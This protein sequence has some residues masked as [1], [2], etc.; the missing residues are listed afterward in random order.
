ML[1]AGVKMELEALSSK[2]IS[3]ISKTYLP[4]KIRSEDWLQ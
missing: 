2:A 4:Q 3:F 1:K